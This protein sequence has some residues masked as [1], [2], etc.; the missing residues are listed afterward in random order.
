MDMTLTEIYSH[1]KLWHIL[2]IS[3]VILL[4]LTIFYIIMYFTGKK[5][6]I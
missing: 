4:I 2:A 3:G 6:I 5:D 1:I